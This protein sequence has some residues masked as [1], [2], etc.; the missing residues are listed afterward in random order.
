MVVIMVAL[1]RALRV[2]NGEPKKGHDVGQRNLFVFPC[3]GKNNG[4]FHKLGT[5]QN[6]HLCSR[7]V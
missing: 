7:V 4:A 5:L 1:V 3:I 2:S 6:I